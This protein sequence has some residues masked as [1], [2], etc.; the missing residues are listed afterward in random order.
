MTQQGAPPPLLTA[1]VLFLLL[2]LRRQQEY[3]ER[4]TELNSQGDKEKDALEESLGR[5]QE[6]GKAMKAALEASRTAASGNI[7]TLKERHQAR[8]VLSS[9][10]EKAAF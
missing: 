9:P 8:K 7:C 5:L 6:K 4:I 10:S 3:L 2:L 1:I